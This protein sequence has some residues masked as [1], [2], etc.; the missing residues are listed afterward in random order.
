MKVQPIHGTEVLSAMI[1]MSFLFMLRLISTSFSL[2]KCQVFE[3]SIN[4][5]LIVNVVHV[6]HPWMRFPLLP[7]AMG[8]G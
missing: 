6:H 2:R 3:V 5:P 1:G 4:L 8:N 7:E